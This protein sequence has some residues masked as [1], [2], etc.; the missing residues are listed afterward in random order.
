M[1]SFARRRGPVRQF[2][3]L[4]RG[5]PGEGVRLQDEVTELIASHWSRGA[6]TA[7]SNRICA[8][9]LTRAILGV[10]QSAAL[11]NVV[12]LIDPKLGDAFALSL[13]RCG[14]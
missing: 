8:Y 2:A 1:P 11:E 13:G 6:A 10:L 12:G 3:L 9:V 5:G 4:S 14:A 7:C